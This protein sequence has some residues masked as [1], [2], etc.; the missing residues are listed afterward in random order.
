MTSYDVTSHS[1][2]DD[3]VDLDIYTPSNCFDGGDVTEADGTDRDSHFQVPSRCSDQ[4]WN[5]TTP[6]EDERGPQ[7]SFT[8][9]NSDA[10]LQT[11]VSGYSERRR[12]LGY[13][14]SVQ[15]SSTTRVDNE[16]LIPGYCSTVI[17]GRSAKQS[18]FNSQPSLE[19]T[20]S[21]GTC[22]PTAVVTPIKRDRHLAVTSS[23][24]SHRHVT[25]PPPTTTFH[26]PP[27]ETFAPPRRPRRRLLPT[28]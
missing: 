14:T 10:S 28:T 17:D 2:Y 16:Q 5:G 26:L 20:V 25:S 6:P 27:I 24:S 15:Q 1:V 4:F 12:P 9:I 13:E 7:S 11:S 21:G 8:A 23:S 18:P 22:L 3:V 19:S